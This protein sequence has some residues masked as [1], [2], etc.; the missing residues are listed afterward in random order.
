VEEKIETYIMIEWVVDEY[1]NE[2]IE[3]GKD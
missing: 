1:F 3:M 2:E